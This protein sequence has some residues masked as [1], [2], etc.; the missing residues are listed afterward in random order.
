MKVFIALLLLV[1]FGTINEAAFAAG[2]HGVFRV[3]KGKVSVKSAQSGQVVRARL[4][5]KVLPGD[6]ISTEKDS[7]A[8]IVMVD[9]NEINIS[10]ESEIKIEKYEFDP[11]QG[12]KDVLLNV[13]YGKVRSKVE[14]KYDGRTSKFQV[15][16]PSAIAGVRGTDFIT[17]YTPATSTSQVI[18]FEGRVEFGSVGVNGQMINPVEIVPGQ[19][20]EISKGGERPVPQSIPQDNLK[21]MDSET[22]AETADNSTQPQTQPDQQAVAEKEPA[23]QEPQEKKPDAP[24]A[25]AGS[26]N[27]SNRQP[28]AVPPRAEGGMI[29]NGDLPSSPGGGP[30]LPDLPP[31]MIGPVTPGLDSTCGQ[32]CRDI[33]QQ[34]NTTLKI[35][36]QQ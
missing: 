13:I 31:P 26:S 33:I 17:G 19:M 22:N 32:A 8:K 27:A 35:T 16:T 36:V 12:K 25:D 14:Q 1:S 3:V 20:A 28:S 2:A 9:N 6:V 34:G 7:R 4:G 11:N 21:Q 18:T 15:K 23:K 10:P 29:Q 30:K 5:S 24:K